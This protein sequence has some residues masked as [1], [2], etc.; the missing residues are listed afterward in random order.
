METYRNRNNETDRKSKMNSTMQFI[1]QSFSLDL[2]MRSRNWSPRPGTLHQSILGNWHL[3]E[4][5]WEDGDSMISELIDRWMDRS[6]F[7]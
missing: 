1:C 6:V 5:G 4:G 2:S 3:S 7:R